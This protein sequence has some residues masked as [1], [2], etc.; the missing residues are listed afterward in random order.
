[1]KIKIVSTSDVHGYIYPTNFTSRND[2]HGLGYLK[3]GAVIEKIRRQAEQDGDIVLYVEDGDFVEGS[4]MT[5][6]AYQTCDEKHYNLDLVKMVNHLQ[7]DVGILGNHEF[8]PELSNFK[9][10]YARRTGLPYY[11][12]SL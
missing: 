10:Q 6:Y 7:A 11:R 8:R 3:A 9:C 2:Y 1:M 12:C 5:D 4:P